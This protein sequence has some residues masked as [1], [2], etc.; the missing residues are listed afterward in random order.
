M[1]QQSL[2]HP[3]DFAPFLSLTDRSQG[4]GSFLDAGK[5]SRGES[6]Q[7]T[8]AERPEVRTGSGRTRSPVIHREEAWRRPAVLLRMTSTLQSTVVSRWIDLQTKPHAECADTAEG[9]HVVS[10]AVR[11]TDCAL[12]INGERVHDGRLTQGAF[13]LSRPGQTVGAWFRSSCDFLHLHVSNHHLAACQGEPEGKPGRGHGAFADDP[14]PTHDAVVAQLARALLAA[15]TMQ[16]RYSTLYVEGIGQAIVT[17]LLDLARSKDL[18]S[19]RGR[20][21]ALPKWRLRRAV[22]Y[23][24]VHLADAVSLADMA[25][26]AGL[27]RMHFA[28]QFRT[29]TGLRPHEYLLRERIARA[30]S[31]LVSSSE[32]LAEIALDVGFQTQSHFTT[33]FKRFT[34]QTPYR[35]RQGHP[36][37]VI[38]DKDDVPEG[39]SVTS[40]FQS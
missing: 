11:P 25:A 17:R 26:S 10:I 18:P 32:S 1:L 6:L 27:S 16:G 38:D 13:H 31:L 12:M 39:H 4:S 14:R 36:A 7:S 28:A 19:L 2:P 40:R 21:T 24:E 20:D 22:E 3:T 9:Y 29:A 15:D 34:G 33:V 5:R 30:E 37:N 23:V 8:A 35:W